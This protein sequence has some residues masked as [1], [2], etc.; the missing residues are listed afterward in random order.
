LNARVISGDP[1]R[2]TAE[3]VVRMADADLRFTDSLGTYNMAKRL[4][5]PTLERGRFHNGALAKHLWFVPSWFASLPYEVLCLVE[6]KLRSPERCAAL[7]AAY[8][9]GGP[10]AVHSMAL[11]P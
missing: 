10:Q 4:G 7:S 9:L 11:S 3:L 5:L 1:D 8:R 6:P 2:Q